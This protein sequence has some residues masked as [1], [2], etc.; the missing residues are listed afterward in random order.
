[1]DTPEYL[2]TRGHQTEIGVKYYFT[3][4]GNSTIIKAIDYS[5]SSSFDGKKIYNLAFGDYDPRTDEIRDDVNTQNGDV[6]KVLNT[7]LY[8][9][10]LFFSSFPDSMMIVRGSDSTSDFIE[11]CKS[12]CIRN[13]SDACKKAHRRIK[14]YCGYVNKNYNILKHDFI[15]YGGIDRGEN[16]ILIEDYIPEKEYQAVFV[17][18]KNV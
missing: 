2:I 6:Y 17:T 3:S 18:K 1:M 16:H 7:V 5:Y 9:I 13:C 10:P 14:L 8:T 11:K 12:N 4:N 15:F